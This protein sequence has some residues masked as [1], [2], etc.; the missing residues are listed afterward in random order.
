MRVR[1]ADL[2]LG[3]LSSVVRAFARAGV[4]ASIAGDAAS[5][6]EA[7]HLV[8]PGQGHFGDAAR[9]LEGELGEVVRD[10]LAAERPYL[11]ICLGMQILFESSEEAE[12]VAG[13]GTVR[14]SVRR[15]PHTPG[16]KVPH[17]GWNQI[18][19]QGAFADGAWFYFVHS[20]YCAPVDTDLA[21]ATAEHG[22]EFCAAL[23]RG[24]LLACQFH[25]EKSDRAGTDFLRGFVAT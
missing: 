14:G 8:V 1:V 21:V 22:V 7:T 17:M 4:E 15:F 25:P 12:G 2:G 11:G 9:A 23:S 6:R 19:S 18:R 24:H 20:F 5:L 13:L 10:H 3:N 16:F